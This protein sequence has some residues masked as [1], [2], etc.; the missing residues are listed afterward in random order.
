[1]RLVHWTNKFREAGI[2]GMKNT[3]M[4]LVEAELELGIDAG[5]CDDGVPEGGEIQLRRRKTPL[6]PWTWATEKKDSVSIFSGFIPRIFYELPH[7]IHI[8][9]GMP[10]YLMIMA[11]KTNSMTVGLNY[12]LLCDVTVCWSEREANFWRALD[13]VKRIEYVERGV[14]LQFWKPEGDKLDLNFRPQV[15]FLEVMRGGIKS[16]LT[17]LSAIKHA[18]RKVKT[19]RAQFGSVESGERDIWINLITKLNLDLVIENTIIGVHPEPWKFYRAVDIGVCPVLG[20]HMSRVGAEMLACGCP[21]IILEGS[22]EKFATMKCRD[23][24]RSMGD[25]ILKV[26]DRIQA[27][28]EGM[29]KEAR[30]IAEEH[31]DIK[32]TAKKFISLAEDL[33]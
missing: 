21:V 28:P 11:G 27:D 22:D 12:P 16:G 33:I 10:D 4:E 9:H 15:L 5:V 29:K 25:A 6:R 3:V 31:Y 18:Q 32:S 23:D 14:D 24:A 26:W 13:G 20:G 8:Q 7:T 19:L 30:R 17:F 1:M 2:S